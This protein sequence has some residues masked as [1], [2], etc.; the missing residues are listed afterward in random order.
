MLAAGVLSNIFVFVDFHIFQSLIMKCRSVNLLPFSC[1]NAVK[2]SWYFIFLEVIIFSQWFSRV[3][4]FVNAQNWKFP[5]IKKKLSKVVFQNVKLKKRTALI[6]NSPCRFIIEI[7]I[8]Y[9]KFNGCSSKVFCHFKDY[10]KNKSALNLV[11]SSPETFNLFFLP[12][13]SISW[14]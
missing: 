7:Y 8:W 5:N 13:E 12:T 9:V 10:L 3:K 11:L 1:N 4:L 6:T 14:V 2:L